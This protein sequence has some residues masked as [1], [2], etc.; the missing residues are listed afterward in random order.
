MGMDT[1]L[2]LVRPEPSYPDAKRTTVFA[3]GVEFQ[4]FVCHQLALRHHIILQNLAS[5]KYQ[6]AIGENLQGFEIKLDTRCV[7]TGRLSIEIA[8]KSRADMPHWTDS[9]IYRDDNS[10]MYIQGNHQVFFVFQKNILRM[11]HQSASRRYEVAEKPK[12]RPTIRTF[13]LPWRDAE[14]Y[15]AKMIDTRKEEF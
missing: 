14:R 13:Y 10:W 12:D 2:R 7:E 3:E 11:L 6:Y 15:S 1:K 5:R 9:G 8:E 4:D